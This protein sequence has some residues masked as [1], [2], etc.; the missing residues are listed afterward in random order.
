MATGYYSVLPLIREFHRIG[1]DENRLT[2]LA[3]HL[4]AA[5]FM[6]WMRTIPGGI[7]H[8]AFMQRLEAPPG[9]GGPHAPGPDKPEAPDV[10][11]FVDADIDGRI[12][13]DEELRRVIPPAARNTAFDFQSVGDPAWTA[14][15]LRTLPDG[16]GVEA[17]VRALERSESSGA[18]A[19]RPAQL[20]PNA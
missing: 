13:L 18:K 3:S 11:T 14:A 5:D 8:E 10:A 12:A 9:S 4:S 16:A 19:N 17:A 1:V 15:G 20:S 7:G 2:G 6:R